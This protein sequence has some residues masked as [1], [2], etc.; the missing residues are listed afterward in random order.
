ML[1]TAPLWTHENWAGEL[2]LS[3]IQETPRGRI[4]GDG[5]GSEE[6]VSGGEWSFAGLGRRGGERAVRV[7]RPLAM[8]LL[9]ASEK[10]LQGFWEEGCRGQSQ[11]R[12]GPA[13]AIT[14]AQEAGA[15]RRRSQRE[16]MSYIWSWSRCVS[17]AQRLTLGAFSAPQP[18]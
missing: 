5:G 8:A 13:Q 17:G 11:E 2:E 10:L 16:A 9:V 14:A 18:G 6:A 4:P 1:Q 3:Q 7:P 12:P 15:C